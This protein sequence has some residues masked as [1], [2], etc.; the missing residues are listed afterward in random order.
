MDNMYYLS[1]VLTATL[2]PSIKFNINILYM[3][4]FLIMQYLY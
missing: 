1:L 2:P 4:S 3:N